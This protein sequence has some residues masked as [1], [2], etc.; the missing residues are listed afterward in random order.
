[1][2]EAGKHADAVVLRID[3]GGGDVL[4]SDIIGETVHHVQKDLNKPVVAS[5]GNVAGNLHLC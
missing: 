2:E 3:S 1:L 4:A 5:F